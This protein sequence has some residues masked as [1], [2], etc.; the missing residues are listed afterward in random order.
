VLR[1]FKKFE[2]DIK[3]KHSFALT[4]NFDRQVNGKQLKM[5]L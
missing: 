4:V 5:N 2:V 3:S 1:I